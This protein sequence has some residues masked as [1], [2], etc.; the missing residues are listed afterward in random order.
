MSKGAATV[1]QHVT[2]SERGH[3]LSQL[4]KV[5]TT[6]TPGEVVEANERELLDLERQG[7][8]HSREGDEGFVDAEPVENESGIITD[9]AKKGDAGKPDKSTDG[10][11]PKE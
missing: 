6:I 8:V 1:A 2:Q 11:E 9:A 10:K 5:R 7:L 4:T 3:A